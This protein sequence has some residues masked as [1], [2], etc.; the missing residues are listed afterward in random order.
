MKNERTIPRRCRNSTRRPATSATS[1][2]SEPLDHAL[3]LV[4]TICRLAGSDTFIGPTGRMQQAI[5]D[6][7]TPYLF[8]HLVG[9]FSLQGISDRAALTYME[10]HD[11]LTWRDLQKATSRIPACSK[12]RG[13]WTYCGCG[14]RKAAR[15]CAE[16]ETLEKCPVPRPALR[17]GRLN[18]MAHSL[19][20]FIRDIAD[21]NLVDWIDQS[22]AQANVGSGQNRLN[23]M[24]RVLID[25]LKNVYGV[26]DKV[27]NMTLA[28]TLLAAPASKP[29]WKET[30]A[31]MIAIDT[32]VCNFLHRSGIMRE[33]GS[34]HVYGSACYGPDGCAD[35]IRKLARQ[36]D[37]KQFN[38]N[39]PR[40]FPRFVQ[41]AVWRWCAQQELN[42]CNGNNIDDRYRCE[43][44]SCPL[45][46]S[47][48]RVALR[49]ESRTDRS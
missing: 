36:I 20:F 2:Y 45:Y 40:N 29:L 9:S 21:N 26:S 42:I 48:D 24:R 28:D 14:Y 25:P 44:K 10:N 37:A 6:R 34:K 23:R 13:Y 8:E 39:Y 12:L 32:L 11:R 27:L 18:E 46:H 5:L 1:Q 16:P 43:N 17:N 3:V 38:P 7:D 22:L 35:V 19:F 31:S 49:D 15:A 33:M 41:H 47:C 4:D 30:G